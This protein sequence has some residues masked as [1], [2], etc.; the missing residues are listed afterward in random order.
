MNCDQA[1][2]SRTRAPRGVSTLC[3]I[4][5]VF[6]DMHS[7]RSPGKKKFISAGA[8]V[9]G[10]S[11]NSTS[12]PATWWVSYSCLIS[13]VGSISVRVPPTGTLLPMPASTWPFSPR[14]SSEPNWNCARRS[15]ALPANTFSLATCSMKPTGA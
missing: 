7:A 1:L 14:G 10:V 15:M 4:C 9:P 12:T 13:S 2:A 6:S 5:V 3:S 11:W 8:S